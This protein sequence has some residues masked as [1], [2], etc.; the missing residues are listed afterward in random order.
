MDILIIDQY[1]DREVFIY[2]DVLLDMPI[3]SES[4]GSYDE[5]KEKIDIFIKEHGHGPGVIYQIFEKIKI[6]YIGKTIIK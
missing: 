6:N 4:V 1:R 5:K 3:S 2:Q